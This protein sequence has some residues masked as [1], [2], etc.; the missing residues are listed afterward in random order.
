MWH[1]DLKGLGLKSTPDVGCVDAEKQILY[2]TVVWLKWIHMNIHKLF[3][4][5]HTK[6]KR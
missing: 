2:F 4:A 3:L 6:R 5:R 1:G